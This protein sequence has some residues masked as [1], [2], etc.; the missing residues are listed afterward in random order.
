MTRTKRLH[1]Q[2]F[3]ARYESSTNNL[4]ATVRLLNIVT[5]G[6]SGNETAFEK[7]YPRSCLRLNPR[8]GSKKTDPLP[9][10]P[11]TVYTRDKQPPT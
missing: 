6:K 3:A 1:W 4:H 7:S 2:P 11:L 10:S 5:M 8:T 9:F